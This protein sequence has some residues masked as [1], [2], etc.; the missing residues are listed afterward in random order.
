MPRLP[1]KL[2]VLPLFGNLLLETARHWQ[3]THIHHLNLASTVRLRGFAPS[4]LF[5]C[6]FMGDVLDYYDD[7]LPPTV[8][9]AKPS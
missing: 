1:Q 8:Y 7:I 4:R 3:T 2:S 9:A 5:L 6:P